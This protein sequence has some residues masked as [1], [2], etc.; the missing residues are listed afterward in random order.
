MKAPYSRSSL[1]LLTILIAIAQREMRARSVSDLATSQTRQATVQVA[2]ELSGVPVVAPISGDVPNPFNPPGYSLPETI[3]AHTAPAARTAP[4]IRSDREILDILLRRFPA[5]GA[6]TW[7]G[8]VLLVAGDKRYEAGQT[9][10]LSYDGRDF[11]VELV[12]V[13]ATSFTL[14]Y[15]GAEISRSIRMAP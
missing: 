2:K 14:R 15:R 4:V 7:G 5:S 11:E 9:L 6:M 10:L 1:L 12:A 8:R 13:T 3:P